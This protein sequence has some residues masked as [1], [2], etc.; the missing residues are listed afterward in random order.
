MAGGK[1][2]LAGVVVAPIVAVAAVIAGAKGK[3]N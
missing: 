3:E 2:I 1:L